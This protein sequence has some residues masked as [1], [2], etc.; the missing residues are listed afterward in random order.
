MTPYEAAIARYTDMNPTHVETL[1]LEHHRTLDALPSETFERFA[2]MAEAMGA[3]RLQRF[4]EA[5][6]VPAWTTSDT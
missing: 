2:R 4:H 1:M 6:T 5:V 3:E